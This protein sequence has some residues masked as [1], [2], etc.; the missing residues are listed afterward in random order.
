MRKVIL[1]IVS[2]LGIALVSALAA[3][4]AQALVCPTGW[5]S[6]AKV[7]NHSS[8]AP[9]VGVRDGRSDCY[10]RVVFD[11]SGQAP[12]YS[13]RYV[14]TVFAEASGNPLNVPG[15]ARLEVVLRSPANNQP[16]IPS[17]AGFT[18]L[19]SIVY[20]GSFEGQTTFGVGVRARLPFRVFLL[21]NPSRVVLD[22]AHH[23]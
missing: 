3:S 22:V 10:D 18:T 9:I 16:A 4:P 11:I 1:L 2:L 20:G 21:T 15:G 14:T 6:L 5:G 12:G 17:T 8:T 13:V 7:D 19:R 23:W